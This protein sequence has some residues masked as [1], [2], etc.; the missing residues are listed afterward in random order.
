MEEEVR[1]FDVRAGVRPGRGF[2]AWAGIGED[3]VVDVARERDDGHGVGARVY[4]RSEV[5]LHL[6]HVQPVVRVVVAVGGIACHKVGDDREVGIEA[7]RV[8]AKTE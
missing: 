4:R 6:A 8:A 3:E 1:F 2:G 7:D 5:E